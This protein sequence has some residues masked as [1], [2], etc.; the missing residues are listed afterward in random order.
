MYASMPSRYRIK[1]DAPVP[2]THGRLATER[3]E[4]LMQV[5]VIERQLAHL[6]ESRPMAECQRYEGVVTCERRAFGRAG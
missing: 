3:D 5:E 2:T 4:A 6:I 1:R